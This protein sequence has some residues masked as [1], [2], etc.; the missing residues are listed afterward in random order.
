MTDIFFWINYCYIKI[1][2]YVFE[3][4][5]KDNHSFGRHYCGVV[6]VNLLI[7]CGRH[8]VAICLRIGDVVVFR[9]LYLVGCDVGKEEAQGR[10][11]ILIFSARNRTRRRV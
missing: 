10:Q 5:N 7:G 11:E 8:G 1:F 9:G 4:K 3:Y 2:E 6:V